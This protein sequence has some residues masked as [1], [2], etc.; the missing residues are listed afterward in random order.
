VAV[1]VI[2]ELA[3]G[4]DGESGGVVWAKVVPAKRATE[5]SGRRSLGDIAAE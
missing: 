5:K 3:G 1:I 4:G 2:G